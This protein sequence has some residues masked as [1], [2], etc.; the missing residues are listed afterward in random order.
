MEFPLRT[1]L[2]G[3]TISCSLFAFAVQA[4]TPSFSAASVLNA[5]SMV[6]GPIAP[7]M[8]VNITGSNLGGPAL[9]PNCANHN[10]LL[11]TC[12]G[13][14]VLVNGTAA[15]VIFDSAT[16]ISFQVPF[17]IGGT[18]ATI[19]VTTSPSGLTLSSGIVTV[20]AAATAPGLYTAN[21]TGSG[22]G[23]YFDPGGLISTYSQPVQAGDIVVLFG[24]G[25]GVTNPAVVAGNLGPNTPATSV[26]SA[27]LTINNQSVP[28]TFAGLEPGNL[29][30]AIP[31]YDEVVF[32][33]P[34]GLAI[35]AGQKTATFPVV[36]TVGG[37]ASQTVNLIVATPP[38]SI[39]SITPNPVPL[40]ANP[41]TVLFNGSGFQN[42]TGLTVRVDGP[43]GAT[44][45]T[46]PN[47]T[48]VSSSQLSVQLTVG[49]TAGTWGALVMNPDGGQ[50]STFVFTASGTGPTATI[51][52]IV[53]TA[54]QAAQIA[55]NTWIEVHGINLAQTTAN[56]NNSDFTH[57]LPTALGGVTATVNNKAAAIFY[58]SPTQ[59]NIL[60]P[61]DSATGTVPVQLTTPYGQTAIKTVTELQT[62]P[63][64]LPTYDYI[65]IAAQHLDYSLLGPV[66]LSVPG[67][68]FT[69]AK[70]GETVVLYATGLGQTNPAITDESKGAG[71][72]LPTLPT[73]TIGGVPVTVSFAGLS[74]AGLYQFNVVVPLG[75][76]DGDAPLSASYNGSSTQSNVLITVQH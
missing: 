72:P 69:P 4:Q 71:N 19:Q 37:V 3:I 74:G 39:T 43:N 48:F 11:T 32:T 40:S 6:S 34:S 73:V 62:S 10:P 25:F 23:Y 21:G 57:G 20:P 51:T 64:F 59:V 36:V 18:T 66:S 5:A 17:N 31:G 63:A 30:G 44:N 38:P 2:I 65:H 68:T 28:V 49:T 12:N 35:P 67:Y 33:V 45:L 16:A 54:S 60:A 1:S 14:S 50:S 7:G 75:T 27:T 61:L 53:T 41:Q 9:Q 56:W 55:Q 15:P 70:P 13:V 42:G 52:S 26:A 24:T 58:V 46:A 8:V 76:P 29:T 22:T 47:V